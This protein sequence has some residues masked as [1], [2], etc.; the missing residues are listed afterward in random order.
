MLARFERRYRK[1]RVA[2]VRHGDKN[3]VAGVACDKVFAVFKY[4]GGRTPFRSP[5]PCF[6]KVVGCGRQLDFRGA[7]FH[8]VA[9]VCFPD[10]AR[11]DYPDSYF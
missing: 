8:D 11:A 6:R 4:S 3:G 2:V 7:P 1:L 10:V 9:Y 5:S